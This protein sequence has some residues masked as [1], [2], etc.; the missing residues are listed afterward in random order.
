MFVINED[1]S[2]Y[3]TRGDV[4]FFT[5]QA[6][7]DTGSY[8]EFQAGDVLRIKIYGKKN[9]EEVY[10]EKDFP[11]TANANSY[12]IYLTEEDTK[13]GDVI[14]KATDYWY[15]IEL[16]P[17]TNPQT[18]IGYDEDGAKIFKLFP[19]GADS[20]VVD[21][22][23]EEIPVVDDALDMTSTR[24]VQNQA[25]ARAIVNLEASFRN[26][27]SKLTEQANTSAANVAKA[28]SDLATERARIDNLV[29]NPTVENAEVADIR[30][31]IHGKVYSSAGTAVR[32]QLL[33]ISCPAPAIEPHHDLNLN[34]Y[35]ASGNYVFAVIDGI[36]N[37]PSHFIAGA[38]I[39]R[40][41]VVEGFGERISDLNNIQTWG[42]QTVYTKDGEKAYCRYFNW[43]Y[44]SAAFVF[45]EW[46]SV[47]R[48]SNHRIVS[49]ATD[50]NTIV[51]P[52]EYIIAVTNS[53]N[54][55]FE[56][57]GFLLS[58]STY[59]YGWLVQDAYGLH[60]NPC[61]YY[62]I[63]NNPGQARVNGA[64]GV[65]WSEWKRVLSPEDIVAHPMP[66][67]GYVIANMGDS[68]V[69]NTQDN[70]S[71]SAYLADMTG[72]TT[73]NFGF[74][75]CRMST[76]DD[77]WGAFCMHS[78][79]DAVVSGDFTW[80]ETAAKNSEVPTYFASTVA[81]MKE[82]DFS[83]VDI[84]TIAYGVNDYTAYKGLDNA[85][86]PKDIEYYGGALR[87]SLEKILKAYPNIRPVIVTPCWC[88]WPDSNGE[89]LE[90]SDTRYFNLEHDTLAAFAN[91]CIEI[92]NEYHVPV[93]DAYNC[94]GINKY[95]HSHWFNPG[96]GIHPN[97]KGR[98]ALAKLIGNTVKGM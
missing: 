80:Q 59:S 34:H 87:Y 35:T 79:T 77:P 20:E 83:K 43:D 19:E 3:A 63:G 36:V 93:V 47:N 40:Y 2:I 91:K 62:R 38:D 12:V 22:E 9:A 39:P 52:D 78:L 51:E 81:K 6:K 41:L 89:V 13:M 74:G 57:G 88:Y 33:G 5:V 7:D 44:A 84:M 29:S 94:R 25:I 65:S 27:E 45:C 8:Y 26:T 90:D 86:N 73:Y 75:G 14:S 32:E 85:N 48:Y 15:E 76:H 28:N 16:N 58:V 24:P 18:I 31:G 64:S 17:Y 66:N 54:A 55:P 21:P 46:K 4:V 98:M 23:P 68:I 96:D 71:I 37:L 10:L 82:T 53:P 56:W 67:Y 97:E 70:T 72:A 69:G 95:N 11:I 1:L 60:T 61:H 50:L 42:R 49:T 92:A 30:V